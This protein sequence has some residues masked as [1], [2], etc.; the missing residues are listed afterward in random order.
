MNETLA[1]KI[2]S[3]Y[4]LFFRTMDD[5]NPW[6]VPS[7]E[8]FHLYCCPECDS[9][10]MTKSH[11]VEHA[12]DQHEKARQAMPRTLELDESTDDTF[13]SNFEEIDNCDTFSETDVIVKPDVSTLVEPKNCDPSNVTSVT[14]KV[15]SEQKMEFKCDIC[16]IKAESKT[17]L[18][19]HIEGVHEETIPDYECDSC[20]KHHCNFLSNV[21]S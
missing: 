6:D 10:H 15:S 5:F 4:F 16:H 2:K 11:F 21:E 8:V 1:V 3:V 14:P 19:I 18:I 12:L 20:G 9:K 17:A 13:A 7:L